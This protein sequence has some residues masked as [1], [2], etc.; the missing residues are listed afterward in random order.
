MVCEMDRG[1]CAQVRTGSTARQMNLLLQTEQ[2]QNLY[3]TLGSYSSSGCHTPAQYSD[4]HRS[5][6]L[7][8]QVLFL[9]D[10][11]DHSIIETLQ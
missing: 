5:N 1:A 10:E 9:P 7:K 6:S 3:T 8:V 11:G 4:M 2:T